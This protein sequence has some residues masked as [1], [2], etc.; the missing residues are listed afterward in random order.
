MNNNEWSWFL[1][2]PPAK[3]EIV[4][5][6]NFFLAASLLLLLLLSYANSAG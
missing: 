6:C 5:F 4:S 3:R 2:A 1:L